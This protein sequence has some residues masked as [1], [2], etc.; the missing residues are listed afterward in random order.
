MILDILINK[1]V[2]TLQYQLC[3]SIWIYVSCNY[4]WWSLFTTIPYKQSLFII[5]DLILN[6]FNYFHFLFFYSR[7]IVFLNINHIFYVISN[8]L[9]SSFF[10]FIINIYYYSFMTLNSIWF[11]HKHVVY[12]QLNHNKSL[13]RIN[14]MN[15]I[16]RTLPSK[17]E[18][19]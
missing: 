9:R 15:E 16:K 13:P 1:L 7:I 3:L 5:L 4:Y 6:L 17:Q 2:Q 19:S 14:W 8:C 11:L 12:K 18:K 10:P